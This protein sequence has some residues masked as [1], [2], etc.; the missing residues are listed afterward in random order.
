MQTNT[1]TKQYHISISCCSDIFLFHLFLSLMQHQFYFL[2]FNI[3]GHILILLLSLLVIRCV[4]RWLELWTL[5]VYGKFRWLCNIFVNCFANSN[6][7]AFFQL[8]ILLM[9]VFLLCNYI[10]ACR[11]GAVG[12]MFVYVHMCTF[13]LCIYIVSMFVLSFLL[14]AL[15]W[16]VVNHCE[17]IALYKIFYFLFVFFLCE[18]Y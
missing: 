4:I 16:V 13:G 5:Y 18:C 10:V 8:I 12:F 11:I 15:G 6:A 7:G 17:L 2:F 3:K 1:I 14:E 9:G